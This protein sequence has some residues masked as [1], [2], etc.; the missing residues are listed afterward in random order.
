MSERNSSDDDGTIPWVQ[1][2]KVID[3]RWFEITG[4]YLHDEQKE[5]LRLKLVGESSSSE[6][7]TYEELFKASP[8]K[9]RKFSF[10]H[11]AQ[12]AL[13]AAEKSVLKDLAKGGVFAGF[14]ERQRAH[15]VLKSAP[16]EGAFIVRF[17][18]SLPGHVAIHFRGSLDSPVR[19]IDPQDFN[20]SHADFGRK[21]NQFLANESL[22]KFVY[23]A[24][25]ESFSWEAKKSHFMANPDRKITKG[26]DLRLVSFSNKMF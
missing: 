7:I 4:R 23:C 18:D 22:L 8:S 9:S 21:L 26:Y 10:W 12:E 17:S 15:T 11:W 19:S 2:L 24:S 6:N 13:N 16:N 25:R 3:S 5:Y 14:M 1:I 20:P